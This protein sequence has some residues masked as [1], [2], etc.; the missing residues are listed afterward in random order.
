MV[1]LFFKHRDGDKKRKRERERETR[2]PRAIGISTIHR[3]R[4]T[5]FRLFFSRKG[6]KKQLLSSTAVARIGSDISSGSGAVIR[7][8][9]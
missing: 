2:D 8:A 3:S 9:A 7:A 6:E 1:N 5:R 4:E